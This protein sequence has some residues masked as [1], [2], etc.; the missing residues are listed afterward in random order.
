LGGRR[1]R[2]SRKYQRPARWETLRRDPRWNGQWCV[3]GTRRVYLQKK[4]RASSG[5]M[6]LPSRVK[7]SDQGLFLYKRT[8]GTKVEK[9][10]RESDWSN[11]GSISRVDSKA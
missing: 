6:G 3:E 4:D 5:G 10:L 2:L 8:A 7:N 9:R 1:G 11:L